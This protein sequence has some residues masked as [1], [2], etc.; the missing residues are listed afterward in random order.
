MLTTDRVIDHHSNRSQSTAI[1]QM[2]PRR[3]HTYGVQ[4]IAELLQRYIVLIVPFIL[5]GLALTLLASVLYTK[6]YTASS[7][8]VF[9]RNDARP[10]EAVVELRRQERD[11]SV[12]ETEL[13]V[14]RSRVFAGTVVDALKL[15]EDPDYNT[16]LPPIRG[17]S[18]TLIGSL[19]S[20]IVGALFNSEG[21]GPDMVRRRLISESVQRNRAISSLLNSYA[22]DRRG[23]SLA[24]T[25][26]V[27]QPNPLK[28]ATIADAIAER[29]VEWTA[30]LTDEATKNTVAYLRSQADEHAGRIG[31]MERE[32][33]TFATNSDLTFDPKDDLLRARME[34]LNEQFTIARVDE[35]GAI[36]RYAEANTLLASTDKQSVG[37]VLTSEQLDRLRSEQSRIENLHAQLSAKFGKNH[38]LV[39]DAD[40]ELAA[41][42]TMIGD[43]AERIVQELANT[44]KIASIRAEKF[45]TEVALLQKRME[46][47]NLA[48]I[49]RREL[50]RDLLAE[51]KRYDQIILRLGDLDPEHGEHKASATVASYAEVPT[52]PSFPT[53]SFVIATGSLGVFVLAI[54]GVV[55]A[56]AL[57]S[58]LHQP[59]DIEELLNRPNLVTVPNLKKQLSGSQA[60]HQL[61]IGDPGSGFSKAMRNLCM[62]WETISHSAGGKI[63]MICSPSKNDGKT[64]IALGM[65]AAAK[66]QGLRAL[67]IDFDPSPESAGGLLGVETADAALSKFLEGKADLKSVIS[68]S[69]SYPFLEVISSRPNLYSIDVLYSELRDRY[70]LI[71]IDPPALEQEEDSVWLASQVDS[72]IMVVA[73][74]RTKERNLVDA[75]NRLSVNHPVILGSVVNFFGRSPDQTRPSWFRWRHWA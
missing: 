10:Y 60:P 35:A 14:I 38:P 67:I 50:E 33:A 52:T 29:Y 15:V 65:A 46:S 20:P 68:T 41:T 34:Q 57:D 51:Q 62:A 13:D 47:R 55:I 72:I 59:R 49:R 3:E 74:V 16:Y 2:P 71:I 63:V 30:R 69:S 43:E 4:D 45:G 31:N 28:A 17:E 39:V 21:T 25:I 6:I 8:I 70:D 26:R 11:K 40:A 19:F 42:R 5:I 18:E 56:N 1:Y 32:I 66:A 12:M 61:L 53:P 23:D 37:R 48:E 9:D 22:V 24:M 75:L 73:A 54:V 58:R 44:A 27:R 7:A 36:A 64:T